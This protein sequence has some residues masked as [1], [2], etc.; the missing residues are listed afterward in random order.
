MPLDPGIAAETRAWFKRASI[1]LRAAD[2]E[3]G[4][5]LSLNTGIVFHAQQAAEKALKGFQT[6][7]GRTYANG[8]GCTRNDF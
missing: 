4:A 2:H 6:L 3:V 5:V 8:K 7:H 1:D